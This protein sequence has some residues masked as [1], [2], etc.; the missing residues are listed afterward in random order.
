MNEHLDPSQPL[1]LAHLMPWFAGAIATSAGSAVA[2]FRWVFLTNVINEIKDLKADIKA[3][4][5]LT[6]DLNVRVA[7]LTKAVSELEQ[8]QRSHGK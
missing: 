7:V 4:T 5:T 6:A 2:L 1:T 8:D 3:L